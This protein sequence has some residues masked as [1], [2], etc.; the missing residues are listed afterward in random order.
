M[1]VPKPGA[2]LGRP[3]GA[4]STA[5]KELME[6]AKG[7]APRALQVLAEVMNDKQAPAPARVSA[8]TSILDRGYGKPSQAV[9]IG[10]D[11]ENQTPIK[12]VQL[13]P[14]T[15]DLDRLLEES[16]GSDGDD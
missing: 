7:Y 6:M 11:E 5:K 14:I 16:E 10:G 13:I 2:K 4:V 1:T 12:T 8:A 15:P 3:K 9:Q